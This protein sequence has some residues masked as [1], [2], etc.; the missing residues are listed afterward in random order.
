LYRDAAEHLTFAI[1]NT[2]AGKARD[3]VPV[4]TQDLIEAKRHVT[5]LNITVDQPDAEVTVDGK[6]VGRSPLDTDVFVDPGKHTVKATHATLGSADST[7]D[8]KMAQQSTIALQLALPPPAST[9]EASPPP[10]KY[11][12]SDLDK[13]SSAPAPANPPPTVEPKHGIE[14]RTIVLIAGGAVTL[15]AAGTGTYLGFKSRAASS[16]IDSLVTQAK[17]KYGDYGCANAGAGSSLCTSLAEK[18]NDKRDAARLANF[19]FAVAGVAAVA[20]VV[21]YALWPK[22]KTPSSAFVLVPTVSPSTGGL[23]L[24]GD[25]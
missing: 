18:N 1:Q 3:A 5:A 7:V 13:P 9:A 20:T 15:L 14:D 19:S 4:L 16:D 22:P 24:Q 12:P 6:L 23:S 11:T 25:F 8:A 17:A 21:T 2:P 10:L